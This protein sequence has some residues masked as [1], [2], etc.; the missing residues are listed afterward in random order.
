[1][2]TSTSTSSSSS[3]SSFIQRHPNDPQ[4]NPS[5]HPNY[6]K[7]EEIA[8]IDA[9]VTRLQR[10]TMMNLRRQSAELNCQRNALLSAVNLPVEILSMIFEFACIP[11]KFREPFSTVIND[12][13]FRTSK[14]YCSIY[15]GPLFISR[16]CAVWRH[17]ALTIPQLWSSIQLSVGHKG[18]KKQAAVLRYWLSKSGSRPLTVGITEDCEFG[19]VRSKMPTDVIAVLEGYASRLHIAQL[20]MTKEWEPALSRIGKRASLLTSLTLELACE[21][22]PIDY[23]QCFHAAPQLHHVTLIG[24]DIMKVDLPHAQ[25]KSLS[26]DH[27]NRDDPLLALRLHPAL[28]EYTINT[29]MDF[30]GS[31]DVV[32]MSLPV[33]H[34]LVSL[35]LTLDCNPDLDAILDNLTLPQLR[36]FELV[37][38]DEAPS[39]Y[40]MGRFFAR[41]NCALESLGLYCDI[42]PEM[43]ILSCLVMLPNLRDLSLQFLDDGQISQGMLDLLNPRKFADLWNHADIGEEKQRLIAQWMG[44]LP[45][46]VPNLETFSCDGDVAFDSRALVELLEARWDD[47]KH[48]QDAETGERS[49]TRLRSARITCRGLDLEDGDAEIVARLRSEGMRLQI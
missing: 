19:K 25:I 34:S 46:L 9:E 13:F 24:Y 33:T 11:A 29:E 35:D 7:F 6:N 49:V 37:L 17:V 30:G 44:K 21:S 3:P 14:D 48:N 32:S 40:S 18:A 5:S 22:R 1:M 4:N 10:E 27:I 12:S 42:L 23:V 8:R 20:L 47:G 2:S 43:T 28:Q 26:V 31:R 15:V 41:S 38:T 36:S 39:P 45:C 16:V